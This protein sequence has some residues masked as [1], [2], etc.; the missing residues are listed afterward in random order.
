MNILNWGIGKRLGS[1]FGIL[2]LMLILVG[3]IS[4]FSLS[5]LKDTASMIVQNEYPLTVTGNEVI[6]QVNANYIATSQMLLSRK[7]EMRQK[8]AE[9]LK[10]GLAKN[11]ILFEK[12][13]SDT[14]GDAKAAELLA[15]IDEV[16]SRSLQLINQIISL[17]ENDRDGALDIYFGEAFVVQEQL[18]Q[19]VS[20]FIEYCDN[21]MI[22]ADQDMS[23][24]YISTLWEMG[25][26]ILISI[27]LGII[28]ALVIT[29]SVVRP[30]M[31]ALDGIEATGRGDMT[32]QFKDKYHQDETGRLLS[33]LKITVHNIS[34]ILHQIRDSAAA[35]SSAASQIAAGNQDLSSRTEEQASAL[36]ETASALEQLTA[37]VE[38][39]AANARQAQMRVVD[40]GA[41]VKRNNEIMS[42][43]VHQMAG[44]HQSSQKM[45]D[46]I[47]VI[48]SIAFQTNILALNAAVE[49]ARAGETGR[50]FAVVAGEVRNLAQKSAIAAKD[51]KALI[52]ESV[53]QAKAGRDLI[54]KAGTAMH[55]MSVN[56][57]SVE[58]I[59]NEI[60]QAAREQSDG[61]RQINQAVG[62]IDTMTQQNAALVEE[63]ASAAQSMSDQAVAMEAL[64]GS[65][66]LDNQDKN[67][68]V[69]QI[70]PTENRV[71]LAFINQPQPRKLDMIEKRKEN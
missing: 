52:D 68:F 26:I 17:R 2:C 3:G 71:K 6:R 63:S 41:I 23:D 38:N 60:A 66:R 30:V 31:V 7:I 58:Q 9:A 27:S 70:P 24:R 56:A 61:I 57:E 51:I 65:F 21:R 13:K 18:L 59:I 19:L 40:G 42:L 16:R 44:I 69:D 48:E 36:E 49:A 64:V 11:N 35:V 1:G 25:V 22:A 53:A 50:G 14:A 20:A 10:N 67:R 47:T 62:Q 45:A 12:L 37:T 4:I 29:R 55:E 39:T 8:R 33:G 46:I 32:T 54:E 5:T 34:K 28:T 15:N 43:T